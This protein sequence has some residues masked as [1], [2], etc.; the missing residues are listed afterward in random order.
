MTGGPPHGSYLAGGG[1]PPASSLGV[2]VTRRRTGDGRTP[3]PDAPPAKL[4]ELAFRGGS[5]LALREG[6]G[7][8]IRLVGVMVVTRTIGPRDFGLYV[9]AAAFAA[10]VA[11]V[12]QLGAEVY[13]IRQPEEPPLE[14]YHEVFSALVVVSVAVTALSFAFSW[15]AE[16]LLGPNGAVSAFRILVLAVPV[17]I[18][19]APAQAR[20]ERHF[21]YRRM[22]L[23]EVA[24]DAALYGTAVPLALLG[25]GVMA[26]VFGYLAWQCTLFAGSAI[27][28]RLLPRWRWSARTSRE[29]LRHGISYS[30]SNWLERVNSLANPVIV[31][32][33]LG[34]TGVGLVALAIRLV[35]TAGFALRAAWRLGLATISRLVDQPQRLRPAL[36][37]G[38]LAQAIVLGVPLAG[39]AVVSPWLIPLVWGRTWEATASVYGILAFT[40]LVSSVSLPQMT[41]LFAEGRNTKVAAAVAVRTA[42][43]LLASATLVPLLGLD[44]FA[45]AAVAASSAW[46]M[47]DHAV[48]P[49]IGFSYRRCAPVIAGLGIPMFAP[50]IAW[51]WR[52]ATCLP[53]VALIASA[54]VRR[55]SIGFAST[56]LR[57]VFGRSTRSDQAKPSS[58]S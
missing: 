14:Q 36:E 54:D 43:M 42:V 56:A 22:A 34:A 24:G 23:I 13:L 49:R 6:L 41:L 32:A 45:V 5:Y 9:A 57:G 30:S 47:L 15:P 11:S 33:F 28:A 17:N 55:S 12:A 29:L 53:A 40:R 48:R 16:L 25:F 19:W 20:I 52:L 58:I 50:L 31:G 35:D 21:Q 7:M 37:E 26:P 38:M 39:L 10:L 44:G 18:L 51:P 46:L 8:L 2:V 27:A 1:N 4:R 3:A